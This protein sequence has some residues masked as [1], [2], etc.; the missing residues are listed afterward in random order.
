MSVNSSRAKLDLRQL[1]IPN[2]L[3]SKTEGAQ[4]MLNRILFS[5]E[6]RHVLSVKNITCLKIFVMINNKL[7]R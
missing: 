5:N 7:N 3:P 2:R 1:S 4:Y 6:M